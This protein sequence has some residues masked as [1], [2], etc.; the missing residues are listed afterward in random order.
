MYALGISKSKWAL[1]KDSAVVQTGE[2]TIIPDDI[3]AIKNLKIVTMLPGSSVI[4]RDLKLPVKPSMVRKAL[5]FQLEPLLPFPLDQTVLYIETY[6]SGKETFV[7]VWAA[8]LM[9]E[10]GDSDLVSCETLAL[11]RWARHF[12]PDEPQLVVLYENLGLAIDHG[13]TVCAMESSDPAR[14]RLFLKQKY[15]LFSCIEPGT[16]FGSPFAIEIGLA[17]EAFQKNPCQFRPKNLPSTRQKNYERSLLK[18]TLYIGAGL[19]LLTTVLSLGILQIR[20]SRLKNQIT[21]YFPKM[22][23][24]LEGA[25]DQFRSYLMKETKNAPTVYAA[26]T[27][28]EVLAWISTLTTPAQI[29]HIQYEL[30]DTRATL[31]IEFKAQDPDQFIKQLQQ[32]PTFVDSTQD[33]K[34]TSHSNG[35][36]TSFQLRSRSG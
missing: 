28:K 14:L 12:Y 34:W 9:E 23:G 30:Q 8:P 35:Y 16:E 25:T 5:P 27:V 36:K 29:E 32:S 6:P 21:A 11:S 7:V 31:Q 4:R 33:L 18:S 20:E 26:P 24:S 3:L 15:P 13:R 17:L 1:L 2:G 10:I 19:T 22:T